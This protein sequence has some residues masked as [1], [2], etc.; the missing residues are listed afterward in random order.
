MS[1]LKSSAKNLE[2][3]RE[4]NLAVVIKLMT[5]LGICSRA[6]LAKR[7]GLR[8]STITNIINDLIN[9]GLVNETGNIEGAKGRRSIGITLNRQFCNVISVRITRKIYLVGRFNIDGR[10]EEIITGDFHSQNSIEDRLF[11]IEQSVNHIMSSTNTK[12]AGIGL[13]VPGPL[14]RQNESIALMTGATGWEKVNL[15]Q[16]FQQRF[17]LPVFIEHDANAG[18][19]A[20]W[21]YGINNIEMGTYVYI[22][23][24]QGI[25]AGIIVDG[26]IIHGSLGIAGE[27][28]HMTMNYNG[29]RCQCGNTGCLE[30]YCSVIA[31]LKNIKE[32]ITGGA[33]T[34]LSLDC[35]LSDIVAAVE[36]HDSF[37]VEKFNEAARIFGIGLVN[38]INAYN[39]DIIVIGD[40]F[41]QFGNPLLEILRKTVRERV[42]SDIYEKTDIRF[43]SFQHD[44]ALIGGAALAVDKLLRRP[45]EFLRI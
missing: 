24:G 18:A 29:P 3:V 35:T 34:S 42:L 21:W 5:K 7:T 1:E 30:N 9:V 15:R 32:G 16:H 4:I 19:L 22:A 10:E 23:A 14:N 43:S 33:N 37:V 31:L 6:D 40:E 2:D 17:N 20:E 39:P 41:I 27:I 13:S 38:V 36:K 25:G 28:G 45:T 12:I 44:P 26:K 11:K 8:G